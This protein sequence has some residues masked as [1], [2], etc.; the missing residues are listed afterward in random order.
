MIGPK[1]NSKRVLVVA[2]RVV[3]QLKRDRRTIGL[4]TFAP[5][6]LMIL[7]GYALSGEMSGINLGVVDLADHID[8]ITGALSGGMYQRLSLACTLIHDPDLLLLDEPTV[9]VDPILREAFWRFFDGL[10]EG[11]ATILITTHL[12]DEAERCKTVGYMRGGRMLAEG[13]PE[14]LKRLAGLRPILRLW[15]KDPR[16]SASSLAAEGLP[17]EVVGGVLQVRIEDTRRLKEILERVEPS[18]LRLVEPSLAA[19]F[20]RL[21]EGGSR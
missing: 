2:R 15:V 4:I 13:S 6:F 10:A 16:A 3:R 7:F 21:S 19:A 1:I 17:V 9:G 11:G 8:R 12:M 20:L 14:E 18:D 5:V